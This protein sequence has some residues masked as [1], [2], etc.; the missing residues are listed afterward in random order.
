VAGRFIFL[1][2]EQ[3]EN[4]IATTIIAGSINFFI[5]SKYK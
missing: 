2:I 4:K 3:E 5:G 1:E